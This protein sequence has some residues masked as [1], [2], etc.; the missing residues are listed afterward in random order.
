[1][2]ALQALVG[3]EYRQDIISNDIGEWILNG[4]YLILL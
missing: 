3:G 4:Q 1:M 2:D